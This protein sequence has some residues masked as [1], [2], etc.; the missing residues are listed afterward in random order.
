MTVS[1]IEACF[2]FSLSK[3]IFQESE[4]S[5]LTLGTVAGKSRTAL[6]QLPNGPCGVIVWSSDVS[7]VE[8]EL[9]VSIFRS[10]WTKSP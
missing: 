4:S 9:S 2:T 10:V 7:K 3:R 1:I 6:E 5:F 8:S